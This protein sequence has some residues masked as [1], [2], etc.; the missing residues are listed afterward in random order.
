MENETRE[1]GEY[2]FD[3]WT[4]G[5]VQN[6]PE[7]VEDTPK[8]V[9]EVI[10]PTPK[11]TKEVTPEIVAEDTPTQEDIDDS[12]FSTSAII[13]KAYIDDGF[14]FDP[15]D[16]DPKMTGKE[17]LEILRDKTKEEV[18]P[19]LE[20]EYAQQGYNEQ[21]KRDIE[22]LRNGGSIEELKQSFEN[23]S[24]AT[25]NI[26]DDEDISNRELLIKAFYREKGF[27]DTKVE[28]MLELSK[29]N[30]DTYEEALTAQDYFY[31]K[32]EQLIE[33]RKA[34]YAQE[35]ADEAQMIEDNKRKVD[36]IL[37]AKVLGGIEIT[38]RE[39]KDIKR[40][41]YE[42]TETYEYLDDHG[43]KRQG[44]MTK[45]QALLQ[46]YNN[47]AEWQLTFTKLLLDGFKFNKIA[48]KVVKTRDNQINDVLGAKLSNSVSKEKAI[49]KNNNYNLFGT[50]NESKLVGEHIIK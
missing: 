42:P 26:D 29:A 20:S 30:K 8:P 16:I 2:S 5:Q 49:S 6:T 27:S 39:A 21:F 44:K 23:Q 45:Y 19:E 1:V 47:N 17:L 11:I 24:Y 31:K 7:V 9:D 48:N 4:L 35:L 50:N 32:D 10:T 41:L 12:N 13:L 33:A 18:R 15:K 37:S 34:Q 36:T 40:A 3:A 25:L 22:F 46:E 38:D 14:A 43:K 28:Q